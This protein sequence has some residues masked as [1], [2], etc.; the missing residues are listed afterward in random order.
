MSGSRCHTAGGAGG[1]GQPGTGVRPGRRPAL[2]AASPVPPV[3]SPGSRRRR[4]RRGSALIVALWVIVILTMLVGTLG[5]EMRI[6][7]GITSHYRKRSKAYA[8]AK[9]GAEWARMLLLNSRKVDTTVDESMDEDPLVLN[10][11]LLA[12]GMGIRNATQEMGDGVFRVDII[13]EGSRRNV[14]RLQQQEWRELLA[15]A[16]VPEDWWDE[17]IDCVGDWIDADEN[18]KLNGAEGDDAYY[19][20]RGYTV[21]NGPI[22]TIDEMLM[23][24]GFDEAILFGGPGPDPDSE[25]MLGIAQWL[26]TWGDGRI[27]ANNAGYEVLMTIP[28]IAEWEADAII[29]GRVGLDGVEGTRDDGYESVDEMIARTGLNAAL[30]SNFSVRDLRYVRVVSVGDVQGVRSGVWAV[31]R[32]EGGQV[33]T[34]FWREEAMP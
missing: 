34:V 11:M 5:F 32:I 31:Y 27:N 16:R 3:P 26:T 28:G 1:G 2:R 9:A 17:L 24:K 33:L 10:P 6:E 12:R 18:T 4:R 20:E 21:K 22:D 15:Q 29:E 23:I 13:P 14:N 7:A 19:N 30:K 25:P 8:L